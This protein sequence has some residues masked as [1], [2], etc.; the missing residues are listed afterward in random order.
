[1]S[2]Q[3]VQVLTFHA[4]DNVPLHLQREIMEGT[5]PGLD[6]KEVRNVVVRIEDIGCVVLADARADCHHEDVRVGPIVEVLEL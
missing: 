2:I 4:R 3:R 5:S 6:G 1:M